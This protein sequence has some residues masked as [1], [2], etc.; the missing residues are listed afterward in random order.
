MTL[1]NDFSH[2]S[3]TAHDLDHRYVVQN[4]GRYELVAERGRGCYLFDADGN[5]YL[6]AITGIGVN[7]LGHSHPRIVAAIT[8]QAA[9]CIHTSNLLHHGY[10]GALAKRLCGISGLDRAVFANSGTEAMETAL[11]AVRA[12]SRAANPGKIRIVALQNSFRGRTTGALAVTGQPALWENREPPRQVTFVTPNNPGALDAAIT[13]DTAAVVMEPVM[14]EA[15]IYPLDDA[16]LQRTRELTARFGAL[17]VFDETQC[18]LGRTGKHFAYQWANVQPDILVTAKPLAAGLPLAAV[19]FTEPVA[20]CFARQSHGSTFA[21]GP[22]ACRVALEFLS[23]LDD[24]LPHI[25]EISEYLRLRLQWLQ[26]RH[27]AIA[28]IRCKG[29]MF[30]VQL[31]IPGHS[32]ARAAM[33]RGLLLQCIHETVLRLLPPFIL[34]REQA[35]EMVGLLDEVLM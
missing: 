6:D 8:R 29:L 33:R 1:R 5:R 28:A 17:L 21:G 31:S 32:I 19:M 3:R 20:Q 35:E 24:L 25:R 4:V 16:Y 7:A 11:K 30:G 10:R 15:G 22:L 34:T 12:F 2:R 18:G 23:I 26:R 14:G 13:E 9:R 27:G